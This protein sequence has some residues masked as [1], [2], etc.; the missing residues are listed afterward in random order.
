MVIGT[1]LRLVLALAGAA[2]ICALAL[3]GVATRSEDNGQPEPSPAAVPTLP[4]HEISA[5]P[6]NVFVDRQPDVTG[7]G[8]IDPIVSVGS[9]RNMVAAAGSTPLGAPV[10]LVQSL[11]RTF[12][13]E[14]VHGWPVATRPGYLLVDLTG[15]KRDDLVTIEPPPQ[16]PSSDQCP[17][18]VGCAT[19]SEPAPGTT[20]RWIAVR[21]GGMDGRFGPA[22][23]ARIVDPRGRELPALPAD[24]TLAWG[25]LKS[26]ATLMLWTGSDPIMSDPNGAQRSRGMT[27]YL[28]ATAPMSLTIRGSYEGW[29]GPAVDVNGDGQVELLRQQPALDDWVMHDTAK[30]PGKPTRV[31]LPDGS[32]GDVNEDGLVDVVGVRKKSGEVKVYLGRGDGTFAA[33]RIIP[34]VNVKGRYLYELA[35]LNNDMHLDLV[36]GTRSYVKGQPNPYGS[37][38]RVLLGDGRGSFG[39]PAQ[40]FGA[41]GWLDISLTDLDADGNVDLLVS[42]DAR[43]D[44]RGGIANREATYVSWGRGDG[45]FE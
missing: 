7:D 45:T 13:A 10:V 20:P 12:R 3:V 16:T 32:M 39:A 17:P 44:I 26:N 38:W 28:D 33:P 6:T 8:L 25:Q 43:T 36:I 19:P 1:R 15:D 42:G 27:M 37:E 11:A 4:L 41:P 2:L 5:W 31:T 22:K 29:Y 18:S 9:D 24:T 40:H 34:E 30:A 14:T 23:R 35:D 21:A